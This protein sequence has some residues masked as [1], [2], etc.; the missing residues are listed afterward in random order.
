[1]D[2]A[3]YYRPKADK[4]PSIYF[5]HLRTT[6]MP[7]KKNTALAKTSSRAA[8]TRAAFVN[9]EAWTQIKEMGNEL[10]NS[11]ALPNTIKNPA[12]LCMVF[13]AGYEFGLSAMES[14]NA[15]YIV[16]GKLTI[17]GSSVISQLKRSGF[18]V[19]WGKCDENE[20]NVT[21]TDPKGKKHSERYTF[22]EALNAGITNKDNWIKYRKNMLRWKAVGNAVRFFC[23]E[24]LSG[25]YIKEDIEGDVTVE[26]PVIDTTPLAADAK[27]P[28]A[29]AA[30]DAP[31][32]ETE[33]PVTDGSPLISEAT[34]KKIILKWGELAGVCGWNA[35]DA[36][37]KRHGTIAKFYSGK[38]SN[39]DLTED[40]A[41][42]FIARIETKILTEK[43]KAPTD[44]EAQIVVCPI[45]TNNYSDKENL[46]ALEHTGAC[47][48]CA[49]KAA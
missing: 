27:P 20:T 6:K 24:V 16:N 7:P 25:F 21:I 22:E 36:A 48:A 18:D 31:K 17:Y 19:E 2:N 35:K 9:Q 39:K 47:V 15:F 10:I 41:A 30:G 29:L 11:Q 13:L 1:M 38:A 43:A 23:P 46:E 3:A 40:E 34:N 42:D 49:N 28:M 4:R 33:K 44:K 32:I 26:A 14:L 45:C 8:A 5:N 37:D 12:Q